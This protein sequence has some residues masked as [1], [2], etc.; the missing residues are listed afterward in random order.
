MT[1]FRIW[2]HEIFIE[3]IIYYS[4]IFSKCIFN[5]TNIFPCTEQ[6]II[7]SLVLCMVYV[8]KSTR[9][10]TNKLNKR[11][12][13]TEPCGTPAIANFVAVRLLLICTLCFLFFKYLHIRFSAFLEKPYACSFL[14]ANWN[15]SSCKIPTLRKK[16]PNLEFFSG[17]Y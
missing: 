3:P 17:P 7:I 15:S 16:C 4:E 9:S 2:N 14:E 6:V 10:L 8:R 13:F 12:L 1:F 11:G 5:F